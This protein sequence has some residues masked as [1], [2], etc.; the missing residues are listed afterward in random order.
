MNW[1]ELKPYK[2]VVFANGEKPVHSVVLRQL[3]N[4]DTIICCDGAVTKLLELGFKP[5][6]IIGDGDSAPPE[7]LAEYADI[8]IQDKD[9]NY[10]DLN[11]AFRYAIRNGLTQI[12]L[13][14]A[15]GLR[16]DHALAN[17]SIVLMFAEEEHLDIV[18]ISNYGVFTPAFQTVTLNAFVG[19]QV[20][21][22]SFQQ[23]THFSFSNLKY[24]V[25]HRAFRHFWEASLNEAMAEQFTIRFEQGRVFVYRVFQ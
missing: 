2:T 6:V 19:Q 8:F 20:S 11:K 24:P 23:D 9:D 10:N 14:G 4:A 15:F 3:E 5:T 13:L 7:I 1:E 21:I 16:E 18:M 17:L 25:E 12:A 22:F